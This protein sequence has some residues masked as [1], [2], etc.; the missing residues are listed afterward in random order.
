MSADCDCGQRLDAVVDLLGSEIL[1]SS[2]AMSNPRPGA[3]RSSVR[4]PV[5]AMNVLDGTQS[6]STQAPPMPSESTTVTSATSGP[7]AAATS[8]AS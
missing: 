2:I 3:R 1:A 5:E 8:A 7:R 4:T 6:H